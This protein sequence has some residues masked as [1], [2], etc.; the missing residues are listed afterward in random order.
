MTRPLGEQAREQEA[1]AR[2][3]EAAARE[4]AASI[5]RAPAE[6]DA[7][8]ATQQ[9]E[10]A[11]R[12]AQLLADQLRDLQARE[13]ERGLVLTL[14]DVLFD[15]GKATLKPG[16]NGTISRLA[17]FLRQS[18]ER[19]VTIEGHTDSV[20]TDSYNLMLS[21]SRA[22]SVRDALVQGIENSRILAV[23]KGESM[24][25]AS[26]DGAA[27]RQQNRRVEIIISNPTKAS[28]NL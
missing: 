18:P 3:R 9:A 19:S 25:V 4:Q 16:A 24:P 22:G 7:T 17:Q 28:A 8:L 20:G 13:T 12:Q 1:A 27:G 10:L 21:E 5:A 11:R 14:G 2:Q 26:N 6:Q 23:G 15:T